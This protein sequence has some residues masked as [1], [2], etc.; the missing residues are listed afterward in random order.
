MSSGNKTHPELLPGEIF[1][2]NLNCARGFQ[3]MWEEISWQTKRR[4]ITGYDMN[5]EII[6]GAEPVFVQRS[7]MEAA[8]VDVAVFEVE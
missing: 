4:G 1:F 3:R 5:G 8:G 6:P 7:E 2:C